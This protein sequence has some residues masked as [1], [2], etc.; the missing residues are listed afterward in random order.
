VNTRRVLR[1]FTLRRPDE[2]A[3]A[4]ELWQQI[5]TL[6]EGRRL[7]KAVLE[8]DMDINLRELA[9]A[10]DRSPRWLRAQLHQMRSRLRVDS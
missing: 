7:I 2:E 8:S 4:A 9:R 5:A 6:A 10:M 3:L 1:L